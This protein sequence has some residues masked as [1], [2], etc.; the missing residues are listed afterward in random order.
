VRAFTDADVPAALALMRASLGEGRVPR[1]EAYF[2]WKHLASP[3]GSSIGLVED[4][5]DGGLL[6][7]RLLQRWR[8][9]RQGFD[10]HAVRAVDTATAPR[11]QGRGL[12]RKLT[13]ASL[14]VARAE[15]TDIVFNTPNDKSGAGYLKM[16]WREVGTL[17][18]FGRVTGVLPRIRTHSDRALDDD[19]DADVV[20]G[21]LARRQSDAR[22]R[23]RHDAASLRWRYV[24]IPGLSYRQ[25]REGD[26]VAVF[27][28]QQRRGVRELTVVE[29]AHPETTRGVRDAARLLRALCRV[30]DA[31]TVTAVAPAPSSTALALL[32]AGFIWAPVGPRLFVRGVDLRRLD[33]VPDQ[34]ADW[35]LGTGDL[36]LF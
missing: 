16:G 10:V 9:A 35:G 28:R 33:R 32:A 23:T 8:L 27:R 14:D 15:L 4:D 36:E 22:L 17:G 3:F 26:A 5:D 13:L 29:L 21:A 18:V 1:T 30:G 34:R 24:D 12:F 2:R 7:L 25:A 6:A 11:A 31:L 20:A 19:V